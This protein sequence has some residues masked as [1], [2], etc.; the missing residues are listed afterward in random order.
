VAST[1]DVG[2][3]LG[4]LV[5]ETIAKIRR[6]YF[7]HRKPIKTICRELRVLRKVVRKMI[8][9]QSG[10]AATKAIRSASAMLLDDWSEALAAFPAG[11]SHRPRVSLSVAAGG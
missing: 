1:G 2:A 11:E 9:L 8:R 4:V 5:A 3:G 7:A 10:F 6:A